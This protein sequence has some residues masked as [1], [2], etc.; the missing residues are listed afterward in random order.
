MKIFFLTNEENV[1]PCTGHALFNQYGCKKLTP[2]NTLND[3][4]TI[5]PLILLICN[6]LLCWHIAQKNPNSPNS[7]NSEYFTVRLTLSWAPVSFILSCSQA[8]LQL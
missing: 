3:A 5:T 4:S 6:R 8:G 2:S 7:N 1:S